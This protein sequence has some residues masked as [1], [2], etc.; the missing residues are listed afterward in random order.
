MIET[1]DLFAGCVSDAS[2]WPARYLADNQAWVEHIPF[3]FWLMG[4]AQPKTLVELGTYS[5]NSFFAFC[6]GAEQHG[7]DTALYAV[8]TW[9]GDEHVGKYEENIYNSVKKYQETHYLHH[10]NLLRST[11]DEARKKFAKNSVDILHIDG[12]HTYQ[13]VKHDFDTW[14][15][16]LSKSGIILFHDIAVRHLDFGVWRLWQELSEKYP[17]FEFRHCNGLGVLAVGDQIP[18]G[19]QKLFELSGEETDRIRDLYKRIG[20][21]IVN[22]NGKYIECKKRL[23]DIES[24]RSWRLAEFV[25]MI[26]KK[27]KRRAVI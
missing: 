18:T 24:S 8:D 19:V 23:H 15:T 3:A 25:S 22:W 10:A 1:G 20:Q 9:Q 13:A 14:I 21:S 12:L 5:G 17:A 27:L 11:F 7:L 2:L 4:A 16:T 6:Q 26:N